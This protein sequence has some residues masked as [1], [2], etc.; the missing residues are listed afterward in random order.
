[1]VQLS[2]PITLDST[3]Y[4]LYA[5]DN[6]AYA[7]DVALVYAL[8][9]AEVQIHKSIPLSRCLLYTSPSPRDS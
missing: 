4:D 6:N 2:R 7:G 5:E 8:P 1:M 3:L 9:S